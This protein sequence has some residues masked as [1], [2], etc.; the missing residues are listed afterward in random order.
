[1]TPARQRNP[2]QSRK[3]HRHVDAIG[4]GLSVMA[5]GLS[6]GA[7]YDRPAWT[8]TGIA[9]GISL[10]ALHWNHRTDQLENE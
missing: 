3:W 6:A 9:L 8:Y 7:L 2:R 4:L 5:V 1:M 10:A